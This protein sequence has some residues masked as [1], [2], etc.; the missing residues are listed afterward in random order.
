MIWLEFFA[1][2]RVKRKRRKKQDR[3]ADVDH[4]QHIFYKCTQ[5]GR[6]ERDN[7]ATVLL[8]VTVVSRTRGS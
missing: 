5:R 6:D 8:G 7:A 3:H 4:V 1:A 2:K